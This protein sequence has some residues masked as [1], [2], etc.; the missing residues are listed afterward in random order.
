MGVEA[1]NRVFSLDYM[2]H[3]VDLLLS[4]AFF[5]QN[6]VDLIF[7]INQEDSRIKVNMRGVSVR[8]FVKFRLVIWRVDAV[9]VHI[10]ID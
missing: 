1:L 6:Q 10:V 9:D 8:F 2:L 4:H 7:V 5:T 3:Q